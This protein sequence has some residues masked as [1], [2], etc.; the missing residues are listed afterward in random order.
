M[1]YT[2]LNLPVTFPIA[3]TYMNTAPNATSP[4]VM[5]GNYKAR[6]TVDGKIVVQS[7][8][9]VL[10]PRIKTSAKDVQ[11]QHDLSLVCYN[12]IQQCIK[13]LSAVDKNTENAKSL[14][15]FQRNFTSI[16]NAL[17]EGEWAPTKQMI[18]AVKETV[19]AFNKFYG[20]KMEVK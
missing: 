8:E 13:E 20:K 7:F 17:Q 14:L 2:P 4:W 5:P 3:A 12:N 9:I 1:H 19:A 10:D 6:L 15:K 18:D 11:L 16:H